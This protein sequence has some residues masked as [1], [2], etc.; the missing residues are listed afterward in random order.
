MCWDTVAEARHH[1]SMGLRVERLEHRCHYNVIVRF[2]RLSKVWRWA[3]VANRLSFIIIVVESRWG[4][5]LSRILRSHVNGRPKASDRSDLPSFRIRR[6]KE[7]DSF[8]IVTFNNVMRLTIESVN[9][10]S[11]SKRNIEIKNIIEKV[12]TFYPLTLQYGIACVT[13]I[14]L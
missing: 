13:L 8:L 7:V 10:L 12:K 14:C 5:L 6:R 9:Y 2:I 1:L 4:T 3:E 11:R